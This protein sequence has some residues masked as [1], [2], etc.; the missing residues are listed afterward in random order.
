VTLLV[1]RRLRG[2]LSTTNSL[3]VSVQLIERRKTIHEKHEKHVNHENT[4]S[5]K[6]FVFRSCVFVDRIYLVPELKIKAGCSGRREIRIPAVSNLMSR[7]Q[8]EAR[9]D[10]YKGELS[11]GRPRVELVDLAR[12]FRELYCDNPGTR[13]A[14]ESPA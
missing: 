6:I 3:S 10:R 4:K 12:R 1:I 7:K 8:N 9:E 14:G 13:S 5:T 11:K 2:V